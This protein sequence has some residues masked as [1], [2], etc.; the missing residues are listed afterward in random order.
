MFFIEKIMTEILIFGFMCY[1][2]F[3]AEQKKITV[4]TGTYLGSQ[5]AHI[6]GVTVTDIDLTLEFVYKNPR[7]E[8]TEAHVVS[9]VT[10][11]ISAAKELV[12]AIA[13]TQKLHE[14]RKKGVQNG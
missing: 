9:R 8:I 4:Q 6:V 10:L 5:Y 13:S 14:A 11:P 2:G 12:E 1:N 7:E 3:M